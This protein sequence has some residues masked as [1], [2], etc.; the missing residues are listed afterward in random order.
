MQVPYRWITKHSSIEDAVA[1]AGWQRLNELRKRITRLQVE[2]HFVSEDIEYLRSLQH[3]VESPNHAFCPNLRQLDVYYDK[4]LPCK[5]DFLTGGSLRQFKLHWDPRDVKKHEGVF[6]GALNTVALLSPMVQQL[7]V[8][9]LNSS[10]ID[11]GKFAKLRILDHSGDFSAKSWIQLC[12]ECP[13]L[14]NVKIGWTRNKLADE[15]AIIALGP[16]M[17]ELPAL[18]VLHITSIYDGEFNP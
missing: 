13:L 11:Y 2:A 9:R 17:Q 8:P 14:E 12:A 7:E 1:S 15:R 3:A 10:F 4:R 16:Q 6:E 5:Y 18:H